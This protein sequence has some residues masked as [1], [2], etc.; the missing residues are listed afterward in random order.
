MKFWD[1]EKNSALGFEPDR[2]SSQAED[3]VWWKCKKCACEWQG[4][5]RTR[6]NTS[7]RCPCCE[8]NSVIKKGV[9][10]ILFLLPEFARIYY[11]DKNTDID[12]YSV[13]IGSTKRAHFKCPSCGHE[14]VSVIAGRIRKEED[15]KYSL[16]GCPV[17]EKRAMRRISYAEEFPELAL[18]F[19]EKL[20]SKTLASVRGKSATRVKYWWDCPSCGRSFESRVSY[21]IAAR[22]IASK[23]CSYCSGRKLLRERSFAAVHP[24]LMEEYA[25]E[26]TIDAYEVFVSSKDSV[27]W[28][29]KKD[30]SHVWYASFYSRHFDNNSCPF[31][32]RNLVIT[33][34]SSFADMYK[35][36]VHVWSPNNKRQPNEVSFDVSSW[37]KWVCPTCKGEFWA[38]INDIT[39]NKDCC[40]YCSK[41]KVH[42]NITSL[43]AV[44]PEIAALLSPNNYFSADGIFPYSPRDALWNCPVC[45]GEFNARVDDMVSGEASCPYCAGRKPLAKFNTLAALYSDIAELLSPDNDFSA[46]EV[47]PNSLKMGKWNCP[48]CGGEFIAR[49]DDMVSGEATCP[50]CDGRKV[51]PGFN[52]FAVKHEDLLIEWDYLCNYLFA[53]PDQ[54]GDNSSTSVW[55]SCPRDETHKYIMSPASRL[56]FQKRRKEPC[57]Y[58]KGRRRKKRHFV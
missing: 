4:R 6:K 45:K 31:C 57:P 3:Y 54:V 8:A 10:D 49:V 20:N 53:D 38:K 51:L 36:Y 21:M 32:R 48:V 28:V 9:N 58:C 41:R 34:G 40:P 18:M 35:E 23:G 7:E 33:D 52:S 44:N 25:P 12:I 19:N 30:A 43:A 37:F 39:S 56:M 15:C 42:P 16:I 55:W 46:E 17:C 11:F 24:D 27:K 47:L 13:G 26:N 50:Y 1:H 2:V 5:I 29:C 14:W 22:N